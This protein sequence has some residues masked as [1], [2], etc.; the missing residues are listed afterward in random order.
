MSIVLGYFAASYV[1]GVP[2][3]G[4]NV[5]RTGR[6]DLK[7]RGLPFV[8]LNALLAN[9]THATTGAPATARQVRQWQIIVFV[10]AAMDT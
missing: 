1:S 8:N 2:H 4:Q 5:R 7:V 10:G 3:F 6:V 9:V